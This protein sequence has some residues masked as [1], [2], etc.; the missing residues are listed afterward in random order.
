MSFD[1]VTYA[2]AKAYSDSKGGYTEYSAPI[3]IIPEMQANAQGDFAAPA[4]PKDGDEITVFFDGV[5]HVRTAKAAT[6]GEMPAVYIG[7]CAEVGLP[8]TDDDFGVLF[9]S[10]N[11]AQAFAVL[12]SGYFEGK[13]TFTVSATA[14]T[15]TIH[16]I[17][18]EYLPGVC[19]P[20]VEITS[21]EYPTAGGTVALSAEEN[22][23]FLKAAEAGL[24]ICVKIAFGGAPASLIANAMFLEGMVSCVAYFNGLNTMFVATADGGTMGEE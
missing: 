5:K 14:R 4:M 21:A 15:K 3:E 8:E 18:P 2:M 1:P 9:L 13:E 7:N 10:V 22:A 16:P 20:V 23:A 17:K 24:P 19:L 6:V 12:D 11:D